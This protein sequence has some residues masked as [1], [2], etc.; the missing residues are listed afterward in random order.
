[1]LFLISLGMVL[2]ALR[3][4]FDGSI[5]S[6]GNQNKRGR[7]K[8]LSIKLAGNAATKFENQQP[9]SL[10]QDFNG[11]VAALQR[12]YPS[13]GDVEELIVACVRQGG[14]GVS[15]FYIEVEE[16]LSAQPQREVSQRGRGRGRGAARGGG[17]SQGLTDNTRVKFPE[18]TPD[19]ATND[20]TSGA[21]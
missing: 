15:D 9:P 20:G 13:V 12:Y 18:S 10:K 14:K 21:K 5:M 8:L 3:S 2:R 11:V 1:M 19:T 7:A 17:A 16:Y 6:I 4:G